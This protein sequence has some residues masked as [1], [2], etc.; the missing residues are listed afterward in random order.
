[1]S[2]VKVKILFTKNQASKLKSAHKNGKSVAIRLSNE[3]LFHSKGVDVSVS[4]DI[5]KKMLSASKSKG[6]RGI[7]VVLNHNMIGG[8]LPLLL[9]ALAPTLISGAINASQGKDF[10]TGQ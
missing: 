8:F 10:F 7:Q 9:A 3:Q 4:Q 5:Y 6:K 2:S 1:M